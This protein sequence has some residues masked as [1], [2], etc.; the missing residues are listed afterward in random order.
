M[1]WLQYGMEPY[2]PLERTDLAPINLNELLGR[3]PRTVPER[4]D[5]TLCNLAR[6]SRRAGDDIG[7]D[8]KK[9]TSLAFAET[10]GELDFMFQALVGYG[11]LKNGMVTGAGRSA[12]L[13]PEGWARFEKLTRGVSAPENLVF[14]AMWFGGEHD[15]KEKMNAAFNQAMK[16]AIEKAGYRAVR[17]DLVEHKDWIMDQVLGDI[18]LAPFVVADF[19]GNRN[20]V[21]FEA[22]FARGLGIPVIHTCRAD[23]FDKAHFDTKQLNHVFWNTPE[24]LHEKLY[25][26]I[27]GSIGPGPY[28][29]TG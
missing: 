21:Y 29:R 16:P 25:H 8:Y 5:R 15:D 7:V 28:E 24:E 3:W 4:I 10:S 22:G 18:R 20:G 27:V 1:F 11:F 12:A 17:V 26:R 2:G 14:V 19:T 9:D 13:T 6:L 23:H